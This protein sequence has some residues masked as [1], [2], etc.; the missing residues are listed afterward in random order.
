[1]RRVPDDGW[2]TPD[3]CYWA[4]C[5][6]GIDWPPAGADNNPVLDIDDTDGNGPENVT[7]DQHPASGTYHVG[8]HYY[9]EHSLQ[10]TG[11]PP[12]DPGSGPTEARVQVYCDGAL[13]A[14]YDRIRLNGTDD[15]ETVAEVDYPSCVGMSVGARTT[16]DEILLMNPASVFPRHCDLSCSSDADCLA[17]ESCQVVS[18]MGPPR[19]QCLLAR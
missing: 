3:D 6:S 12:I 11:E 8:V 10:Q 4:T 2:F 7:I 15:W 13:I 17:N 19:L 5:P 9:C 1:V 18:G 14:T 16:G